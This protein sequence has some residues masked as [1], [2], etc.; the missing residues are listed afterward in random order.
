[1]GRETFDPAVRPI[2][3]ALNGADPSDRSLAGRLAAEFPPGGAVWNGVRDA[4]RAGLA[5]GWLC[6]R[7]NGGIRFSRPVKPTPESHGWSVDAVDM[8]DVA[9]PK[10]THV[11]GEVNLC[12]AEGGDPK[13][14]GHGEGWVV[15]PPMSTHVPRVEGGRMVILYFLPGGAIE[16]V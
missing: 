8:N 12:M 14:C 5:E 13:F 16:F 6:N 4:C 2:L 15:F 11:N 10:H 3:D 7:E 1:M 9:G